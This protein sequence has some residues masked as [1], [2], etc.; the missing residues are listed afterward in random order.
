[1]ISSF[2]DRIEFNLNVLI[3][4]RNEEGAVTNLLSSL[5]DGVSQLDYHL[6]AL[7]RGN[8]C[9]VYIVSHLNELIYHG[10][11]YAELQTHECLVS[12][13]PETLL[14]RAPSTQVRFLLLN[15]CALLS[16]VTIPSRHYDGTMLM[17]SKR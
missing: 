12:I 4:D 5:K 9:I 14:P 6:L 1:V 17:R 15:T 11:S 2:V 7:T 10:T 13:R 16:L 8:Q 3:A